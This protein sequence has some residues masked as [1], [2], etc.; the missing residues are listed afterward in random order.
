MESFKC[1]KC[2]KEIDIA[3]FELWN[4]Y[5]DEDHQFISCP[6]CDKEIVVEITRDYS[7][8]CINE[9]DI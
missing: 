4:L 2:N 7:F 6:H 5:C 1:N 9:E 3:Q 8:Q